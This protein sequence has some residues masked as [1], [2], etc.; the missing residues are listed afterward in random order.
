MKFVVTNRE[1]REEGAY[2][3][4]REWGRRDESNRSEG[5]ELGR[6]PCACVRTKVWVVLIR[7]PGRDAHAFLER[8]PRR[9]CYLGNSVSC[10]ATFASRV[11]TS[12]DLSR[13]ASA[14]SGWV[15]V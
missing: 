5:D 3:G 9:S 10:G 6:A 15:F 14:E 8:P 1:E 2:E 12:H 13:R 11:L 7:A 4:R